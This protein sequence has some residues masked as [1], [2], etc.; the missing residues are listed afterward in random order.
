MS[1]GDPQSSFADIH[2][3]EAV[4]IGNHVEAHNPLTADDEDQGGTQLTE[5]LTP[6]DEREPEKVTLGIA[7]RR[8]IL[9]VE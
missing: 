2:G 3:C 1:V 6:S 8:T 9:G 4:R 7:G 5:H